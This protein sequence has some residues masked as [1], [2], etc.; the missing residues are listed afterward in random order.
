MTQIS[1]YE[2]TIDSEEKNTSFCQSYQQWSIISPIF[3]KASRC[4]KSKKKKK[5]KKKKGRE[6]SIIQEN[7]LQN[8]MAA[9]QMQ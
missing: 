6:K 4:R 3:N 8:K 2:M 1:I 9:Y 7:G 5:K